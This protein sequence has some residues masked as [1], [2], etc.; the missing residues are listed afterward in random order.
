MATYVFH[1]SFLCVY[2]G[3]IVKH[4]LCEVDV[5]GF[6]DL[7]LLY[8]SFELGAHDDQP[9]M[10]TLVKGGKGAEQRPQL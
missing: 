7:H 10:A 3:A 6:F 2:Y 5:H 4:V 8:R 9:S 1:Y